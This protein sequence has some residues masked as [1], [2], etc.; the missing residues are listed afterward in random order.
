M[1]QTRRPAPY[2]R[3]YTSI[4]SALD[5]LQNKH[6]TLLDPAKW[7][8]QNDVHYL[9]K[10]AEKMHYKNVLVLCFA[11]RSE[12]FHHWK[13]FTNK[14]DGIC[15]EF[16]YSKLLK[17]IENA[18]G[19]MS[20]DVKYLEITKLSKSPPVPDELP[21]L[22]RY[23]YK[24]EKEFR[25][26]Y[27]DAAPKIPCLSIKIDLEC[28]NRIIVNPWLPVP[29]FDSLKKTIHDIQDCSKLLVRSTTLLSNES[30]KAM[31]ENR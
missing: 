23:P 1:S 22:K 6:I 19:T 14:E 20:R 11:R 28:I 10:Y 4:A 9:R 17:Y 29:L 16:S 26:V 5:I 13:V 25:I 3:R 21:F 24:D 15:V 12:T 18:E 2:L 7:D 31:A 30:W 27:C 8:D